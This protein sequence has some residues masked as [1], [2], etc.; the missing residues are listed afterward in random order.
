MASEGCST[1]GKS[2]THCTLKS[3]DFRQGE[4]SRITRGEP[5]NPESCGMSGAVSQAGA[6]ENEGS[7]QHSEHRKA[8]GRHGEGTGP[9]G[10]G[11]PCCPCF[12]QALKPRPQISG[13]R[14]HLCGAASAPS[15][16]SSK[17]GPRGPPR[18]PR[19]PRR[20]RGQG[21]GPRGPKP[22]QLFIGCC[23]GQHG[24][25]LGLGVRSLCVTL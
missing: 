17:G 8:R 7:A 25:V 1:R 3:S 5:P 23:A 13:R 22:R 11:G 12:A 4:S 16:V 19:G 20:R 15:L 18:G 6:V 21:P 10:P 2:C 14:G 24:E 9:G